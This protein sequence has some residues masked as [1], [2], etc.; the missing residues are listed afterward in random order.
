MSK[1]RPGCAAT[2]IALIA[3]PASLA[4]AAITIPTVTVG[5]PGNV[6]DSTNLG[7]VPYAYNMAT[8]EVTAGQYTAF[9]NAVARTDTHNL[10]NTNMSSTT[11]GSGITRSQTS[12]NYTYS[13]HSDFENRPVNF[14]SFWDAARFANWLQNGQPIGEQNAGTTEDGTYTLTPDGIASNAVTRN[15]GAQW[16]IPSESEW[17]KA[18]YYMGGGVSSGYWLY[19]T[20]SNTTPGSNLL[21]AAGNNA[22]YYSGSPQFPIDTPFYTTLVGQFQNSASPYGTFD[23]GGNLWEW[24]DSILAGTDRGIRGGSYDCDDTFM[25]ATNRRRTVPTNENGDF[26]FRVSQIPAPSTVALLAIA[27]IISTRRR[28]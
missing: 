20:S 8:H 1:K 11:Y 7:S 24:N 5:H 3:L 16:V 19:P 21:D 17:Y 10:Y 22:N 23:Q 18:A 13:V 14:V 28:R 9:L 27:G 26:G 4:S 15:T 2:L 6:A 25:L 12:G